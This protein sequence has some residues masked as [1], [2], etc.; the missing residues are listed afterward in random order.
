MNCKTLKLDRV[1]STD[2]FRRV[3]TSEKAPYV[4]LHGI[5]SDASSFHPLMDQMTD[6]RDIIVWNAP[7]YGN[8]KH[9]AQEFPVAMDYADRLH[10]ILVEID[11]GPIILVGHSLGTLMA[12]A[13]ANRY[14]SHVRAL[15]LLASAQGYG[16][17]P[18]QEL[19]E[20]SQN[21]LDKLRR[22]G[23]AKFAAAAAPGLIFEPD[24]NSDLVSNAEK[25]MSRINSAGYTQAVKMLSSGALKETATTVVC[26]SLTIVGQQDN[27][28]P[29]DQSQAVH[30]SL[31]K[32]SPHLLHELVL[33]EKAAHAVHQQQPATVAKSMSKFLNSVESKFIEEIA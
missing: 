24:N 6:E 2:I 30:N 20:K 33:I 21:R 5:G 7:G 12:I 22:L 28:T 25:A 9:L 18:D 16:C 13:F 3:G 1:K 4:M 8:S 11:A 27:I 15:V 23:P 26:P 14:P 10:D 31:S 29:A 17:N 19:P 32:A